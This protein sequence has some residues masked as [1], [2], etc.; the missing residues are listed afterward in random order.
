FF[1]NCLSPA[2]LF[3]SNLSLS[4]ASLGCSAEQAAL[5][6]DARTE[7][8]ARLRLT[9][10]SLSVAD[11]DSESAVRYRTR[12]LSEARAGLAAAVNVTAADLRAELLGRLALAALDAGATSGEVE[13]L[14]A[15]ILAAQP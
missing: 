5:A 13:S 2:A 7:A 1:G 6:G 14:H 9:R 8:L 3:G 11:T 12:A 4:L 15:A 10:L